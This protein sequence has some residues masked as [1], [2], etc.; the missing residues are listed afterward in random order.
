MPAARIARTE[1]LELRT[2]APERFVSKMRAGLAVEV[3]LAAWPGQVFP[4]VLREVA[5]V[6]DPASR[7]LELRIAFRSRDTRLKAGM[8]AS[9]KVITQDKSSVVKVPAE[10]VIKRFDETFAFI[11]E[12]D[13][14]NPGSF[15]ARKRTVATG[16][17]I[18]GVFEIREGLADGEDVVVRG[19]TLLEEGVP[20]N[21][22]LRRPTIE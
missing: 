7:T 5:P 10:A 4:A 21:V 12:P 11:V 17:L 16:I 15:L 8:F 18:D 3:S 6:L 22:V 9:V 14:A 13:P 20:V 1:D 2:Y 19:Q